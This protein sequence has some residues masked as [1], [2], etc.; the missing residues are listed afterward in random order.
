[1]RIL[2]IS[3]ND[4]APFETL[5]AR[6]AAALQTLGH[7]VST[8]FLRKPVRQPHAHGE[9]L[10]AP[11]KR[12]LGKQ[13]PFDLAIAH[14]YRSLRSVAASGFAGPVVAVAHEFG[15]ARQG[16][17]RFRLKLRAKDVRFAGVSRAVADDLTSS[18]GRPAVRLPNVIDVPAYQDAL[19]PRDAARRQLNIEQ[20]AFVIGVLGRLH[21]W[22][23]PEVA[24]EAF[25]A[26]GEPH[27]RL[28]VLGDGECF[29]ALGRKAVSDPRVKLYGFRPDARE[30][31]RAFDRV[32]VASTNREAFNMVALEAALAGVPVVS[33][34]SPGPSEVLAGSARFADGFDAQALAS[35]LRAEPVLPDSAA[36]AQRFGVP[37]L[38]ACLDDLLSELTA[39]AQ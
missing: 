37:A 8:L 15:F 1:M 14:R 34:P 33:T 31:Y 4:H 17:R 26:V 22:K 36:L 11:L 20:D 24:L 12:W 27:W 7:E 38:A 28:A 29:E 16:W 19:L 10:S 3:P 6:Y 35:S 30:L 39:S 21:W 2:Q 5:T 18:L 25:E 23:Q 32:L 13:Q 9:Y